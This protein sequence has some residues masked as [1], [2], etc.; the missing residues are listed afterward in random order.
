MAHSLPGCSGTGITVEP[1]FIEHTGQAFSRFSREIGLICR[2]LDHQS[3][4]HF[5]EGI[6]VL[7]PSPFAFLE[8][9]V[10]VDLYALE[11]R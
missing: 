1:A 3:V 8:V 11:L 6:E 10:E 9:E 5:D 7:A 4:E 2:A